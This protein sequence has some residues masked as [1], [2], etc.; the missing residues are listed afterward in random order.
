MATGF[1]KQASV[2][3]QKKKILIGTNF[4]KGKL[5]FHYSLLHNVGGSWTILKYMSVSWKPP[6]LVRQH[7]PFLETSGL[8]N[9]P[10]ENSQ[11]ILCGWA[12][13]QEEILRSQMPENPPLIRHNPPLMQSIPGW[14][15]LERNNDGCSHWLVFLVQFCCSTR[16]CDTRKSHSRSSN[17]WRNFLPLV[18]NRVILRGAI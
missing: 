14:F 13:S 8:H 1:T 6:P 4:T 3:H 7:S 11:R 15:T 9:D 12:P 18:I 5:L 17:R 16:H 2:F 10:T